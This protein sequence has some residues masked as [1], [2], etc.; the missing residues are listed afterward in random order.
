MCSELLKKGGVMQFYNVKKRAKVEV[1]DSN[2]KKKKY[3]G[4]GGFRYAV[5]AVDDDGM[6]LTKFVKK[7]VY[8]S[9]NVPEE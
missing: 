8:D 3:E 7:E 2:I 4:R 1:A 5:R 9:L 6:H